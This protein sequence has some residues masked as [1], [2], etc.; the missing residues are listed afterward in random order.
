MELLGESLQHFKSRKG[1]GKIKLRMVITAFKQL[2]SRL[3]QFYDKG[4]LHAG[5][6]P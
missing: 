3:E 4:Y 6:K 1:K 2:I 5:I